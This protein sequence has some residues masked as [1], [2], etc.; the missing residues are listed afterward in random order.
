MIDISSKFCD[1]FNDCISKRK[2]NSIIDF[3]L[4]DE[5]RCISRVDSYQVSNG[6]IF[7]E[8]ESQ[9]HGA[10]NKHKFSKERY[11]ELN[12]QIL[13]KWWFNEECL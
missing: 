8:K 5:S 6:H 10:I 4:I 12:S 1:I 2:D 7:L 13:S 9:A 3:S 11:M